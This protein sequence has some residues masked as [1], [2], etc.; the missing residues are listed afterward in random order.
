[1]DPVSLFLLTVAA[2][3]LIGI[4]GELV[5]EKTGV[6]DVV[7]LML[8]GIVLGPATGVVGR[9]QLMAIAPYFG[10]LTLVIVLFD[11]GSELR[12]KELSSA[13]PR[14]SLLAV[15][16]FSLSLVVIAPVSM[17]AAWSGILPSSW[18]W[19]HGLTLAAIIGGSSSVVVMPALRMA[20]LPATM[21][22]LVNL[23]SALTDV[24]CVVVTGACVDILASGDGESAGAAVTLAKSFGIGLAVG[25]TAGMLSLLVLRRLK[26]SQYAYPITLGALLIL[27]V[28]IDELGGSAALG[29]L[30]MAVLVGNAPSL[31]KAV[32]LAKAASLGRGVQTIHDQITFII[33]S[34]FFTF[35][36]AMLGPPWSMVAFGALL[37]AFLLLSRIPAVLVATA[38]G[39][40]TAPEK[41]LITVCLPR[42]IAAGVLALLPYQNGVP[43]TEL[44]PVVVFAAVLTTIVF[45]AVGFPLFKR[46]LPQGAEVPLAAMAGLPADA[47]ATAW[48]ADASTTGWA[49]DG[50]QPA[51]A[52]TPG[53]PATTPEPPQEP[54]ATRVDD[55]TAT[56]GAPHQAGGVAVALP[57]RADATS[58]SEAIPL[59]RPQTPPGG[60]RRSD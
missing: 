49:A 54:D 47:S 30:T 32:G 39:N 48:P 27:Y 26:K 16:S 7:W 14:G 25:G 40:F 53:P 19:L 22:N 41:K 56:A 43:G 2:I 44:L 36:G 50:N 59:T 29:I 45:F 17:A 35:I 34:F 15:L 21:A 37:G 1:M 18:T 20:R 8:V 42:G 6:P 4:I 60:P 52:P 24:L 28:L 46:G 13:L 57:L 9:E 55:P 51:A 31:S 23:E 58:E 5:F 33:K 38:R 11:G 12:L 10:A 3:F